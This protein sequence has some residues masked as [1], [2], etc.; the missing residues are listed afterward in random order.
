MQ[1]L[2]RVSSQYVNNI[3][4]ILLENFKNRNEFSTGRCGE[5]AL[6]MSILFDELGITNELCLI[7]D[8]DDDCFV[9]AF[10][11]IDYVDFDH[12]S[13]NNVVN[14]WRQVAYNDIYTEENLDYFEFGV[15]CKE[16]KFFAPFG[17]RLLI[18]EVEE[19]FNISFN[20]EYIEYVISETFG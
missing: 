17:V 2:P 11:R 5:F 15:E 19:L 12:K 13:L 20:Q 9:H 7:F 10:I 8:I 3:I 16:F 1:N 6:V 18:S 14:S 4:N